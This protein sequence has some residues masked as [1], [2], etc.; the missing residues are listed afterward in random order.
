MAF[1]RVKKIKQWE[2]AYLVENKWKGEGARQKVK[3]YLGRVHRLEN[4]K[5]ISVQ[6]EISIKDFRQAIEDITHLELLKKGFSEKGG[7]LEKGGLM[8][9]IKNSRFLQGEKSI[10]LK[11][12]EGFLCAST[13]AALKDFRAYGT[14]EEVGLRLA[15]AIVDAGLNIPEQAFVKIFET[16]FR[17][18]VP[19]VEDRQ[20][21]I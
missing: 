16:K 19:K 7:T 6:K 14:E 9:D 15:Q 12:N 20:K 13:L 3:G 11:M 1:I 10:V 5:G 17:A 18:G 8:A 2:Y 4:E 21:F